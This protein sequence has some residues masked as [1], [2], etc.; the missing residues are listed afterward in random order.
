MSTKHL[1]NPPVPTRKD[2]CSQCNDE[3]WVALSS[4][5]VKTIL[6]WECAGPE[7]LDADDVRIAVT[8]DQL[9]D[10]IRYFNRK[11]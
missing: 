7:L 1:R 10:I 9:A 8:D 4:P 2:R 11:Q 6:C 5:K 3:V